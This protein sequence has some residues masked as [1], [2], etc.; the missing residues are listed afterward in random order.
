VN[1]TLLSK[2]YG[3]SRVSMIRWENEGTYFGKM[4]KLGVAI[5]PEYV[6]DLL[7]AVDA[8]RLNSLHDLPPRDLSEAEKQYLRIAYTYPRGP[9]IDP[10]P[11]VEAPK[12]YYYDE[13]KKRWLAR[14]YVC[15]PSSP[16]SF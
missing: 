6:G 4:A 15:L 2:L 12:G 16:K 3:I 5:D 8:S 9:I 11:R 13:R 7:G 1:R 14:P 10:R